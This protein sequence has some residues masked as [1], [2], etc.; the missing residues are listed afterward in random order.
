MCSYHITQN[1]GTTI[2]YTLISKVVCLELLYAPLFTH[3][4]KR[5]KELLCMNLVTTENQNDTVC[6]CNQLRSGK[7]RWL[8]CLCML[9]V[10]D[11]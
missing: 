4:Y 9:S 2:N 5:E 1:Y 8:L 10:K 6:P 3:C 7:V 11:E